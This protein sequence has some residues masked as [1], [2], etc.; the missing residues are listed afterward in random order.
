VSVN[1][2]IAPVTIGTDPEGKPIK[3]RASQ[4][5]DQHQ[6]VEQMAG[7]RSTDDHRGPAAARRRLGQLPGNCC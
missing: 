6:P 4:W 5:L 7:A 2:R 1:A 3:L